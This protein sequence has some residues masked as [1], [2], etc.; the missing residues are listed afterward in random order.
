MSYDVGH[1]CS[2]DPALPWLWH[3]KVATAPIRPLAWELPCAE[4]AA[5][6]KAKRQKK[7]ALE[8]LEPKIIFIFKHFQKI[9]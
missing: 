3:R 5:L 9:I 6:E 2:S 7:N 8:Q 4:E 1:R